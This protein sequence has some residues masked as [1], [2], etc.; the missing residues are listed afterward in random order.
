L[1]WI[2]TKERNEVGV[3]KFHSGNGVSVQGEKCGFLRG[4]SCGTVNLADET[5]ANRRVMVFYFRNMRI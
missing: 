3:G 4:A 1:L 5:Y 2:V